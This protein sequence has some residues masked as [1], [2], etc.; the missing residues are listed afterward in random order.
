MTTLEQYT[1]LLEAQLGAILAHS[2][3]KSKESSKTIR[4]LSKLLDNTSVA[5]RKELIELDKSLSVSN[6]QS[7]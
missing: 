5:L 2:L 7:N 3:V 1:Q 6:D 4:D